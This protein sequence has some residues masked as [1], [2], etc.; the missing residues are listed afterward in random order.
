MAQA[1]K[2]LTIPY[3]EDMR[4]LIR[5]AAHR[6]GRAIANYIRHG[7]ALLLQQQG[8][9]DGEFQIKPEFRQYIAKKLEEAAV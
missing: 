1:D 7:T 3:T 9:L 5:L 2:F 6:D 4:E 8:F